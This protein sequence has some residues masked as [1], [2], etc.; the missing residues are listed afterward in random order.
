M[1]EHKVSFVFHQVLNWYF[2]Y[3]EEDVGFTYVFLDDST[4]IF[5]FVFG[6]ASGRRWLNQNSDTFSN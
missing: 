1:R 6:V 3:A 2:F 4:G 5:E